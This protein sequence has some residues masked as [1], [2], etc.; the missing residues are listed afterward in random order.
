MHEE[1]PLLDQLHL[2]PD[3]RCAWLLLGTC[4]SAAR[5]SCWV[6]SLSPLSPTTPSGSGS[7]HALDALIPPHDAAGV[8]FFDELPATIFFLRAHLFAC[9]PRSQCTSTTAYGQGQD[10][11]RRLASRG[12]PPPAARTSWRSGAT[13]ASQSSPPG[14][15]SSNDAAKA[16]MAATARMRASVGPIL[17]MQQ[18]GAAAG[19]WPHGV[20]PGGG[21]GGSFSSEAP[22]Y[23]DSNNDE[24]RPARA[25]ELG[26]SLSPF[27][28]GGGV[29]GSAMQGGCRR[30]AAA[31][32]RA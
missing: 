1:H 18:P 11:G 7:W 19:G 22:A 24:A 14:G 31:R 8:R 16:R 20:V 5:L 29:D 9:S 12:P 25:R 26:V 15:S 30:L 28:A 6:P 32:R 27:A 3:L 10:A 4:S 13:P 17:H 2:L 23:L 21:E